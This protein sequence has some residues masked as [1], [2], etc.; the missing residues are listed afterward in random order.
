M[1]VRCDLVLLQ[2]H[3]SAHG[4]SI[5]ALLPL[6]I[7]AFS[8]IF[9]HNERLLIAFLVRLICFMALPLYCA[10]CLKNIYFNF[11]AYIYFYVIISCFP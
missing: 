5:S 4:M 3:H 7:G 8:I 1:P 9:L 6:C 2:A 11:T 10:V